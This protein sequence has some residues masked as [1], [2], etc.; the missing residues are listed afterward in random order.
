MR[1]DALTPLLLAAKDAPSGG[2][3][4][5]EAAAATAGALVVTTVMLAI[6]AGHRSGRLPQVGRL[7]A[8]AERS[9]GIPG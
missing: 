3:A 2:A 4:T 9:S 7:A 8:F 5:G 1:L 6:V